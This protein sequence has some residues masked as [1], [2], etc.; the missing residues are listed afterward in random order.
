[1]MLRRSAVPRGFTLVEVLISLT[2]MATT[3][4]IMWGAFSTS[5]RMREVATAR[6]DR[7]RAIHA[8]MR[9]MQR[10]ISMAFVSKIGQNPTNE[11]GEETYVTAFIGQHDRLDF[12]NFAHM[13]T[14]ADEVSSEQAEISYYLRSKRGSDGRLHD[15]LV[16]REQAPIDGDPEEGGTIFVLLEDVKSL[17]F[18]YWRPD[19]EIA[20]DA[21]E[22]EWDTRDV[23][24]ATL[25][26]RVRITIEVENPLTDRETWEFSIQSEIHLTTPIGF[27]AQGLA[28]TNNGLPDDSNAPPDDSTVDGDDSIQWSPNPDEGNERR[29]E[30]N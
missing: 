2:I 18:D 5:N 8:A 9:R 21:W 25:P 22:R 29:E 13:R 26:P 7:L 27:V 4:A 14:R 16:R 10:E 17:E 28:P 11:R 15:S 1:M 23:G 20:G 12:S 19:R 30:R 24:M 6:Y 3:F